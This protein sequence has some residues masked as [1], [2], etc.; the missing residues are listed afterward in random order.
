MALKKVKPDPRFTSKKKYESLAHARGTS[1]EKGKKQDIIAKDIKRIKKTQAGDKATGVR[2]SV[3]QPD[4]DQAGMTATDRLIQSR[5]PVFTGEQ[6]FSGTPPTFTPNP[7]LSIEEQK[8]E[9]QGFF[10]RWI[11]YSKDVEAEMAAAKEAGTLQRTGTTI[12][13]TLGGMQLMSQLARKEI[14][15]RAFEKLPGIDL[16]KPIQFQPGISQAAQELAKVAPNFWSNKII[17]DLVKKAILTKGGRVLTLKVATGIAGT[18][19][20]YAWNGHLKL[21]NVIG[22][23][24]LQIY[25]AYDSGNPELANQLIEEADQ[26]LDPSIYEQVLDWIPGI[27][28]LKTTLFDGIKETRTGFDS[29]KQM[30]ADAPQIMADEAKYYDDLAAK[31][32]EDKKIAEEESVARWEAA[33]ERSRQADLAANEAKSARIKKD[34]DERRKLDLELAKEKDKLFDDFESE[35]SKFDPTA[36]GTPS[37]LNFG[38]IK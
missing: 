33:M 20:I 31:R 34:A 4:R 22:G 26:Y 11:K 1:V 3:Q 35:V 14:A 38:L 12:G 36:F 8:K 27:N 37:A 17:T 2:V 21:D 5:Q 10:A 15:R 29:Y 25:N 19:M 18:L 28:I 9:E 30:I 32:A 24:K 23:Y 13:P 7:N 16:S 6:G